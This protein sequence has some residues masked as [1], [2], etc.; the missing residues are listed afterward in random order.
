MSFACAVT[1]ANVERNIGA[2]ENESCVVLLCFGNRVEVEINKSL[3]C[4][5]ADEAGKAGRLAGKSGDATPALARSISVGRLGVGAGG[6]IRGGERGNG[7][8]SH[9]STFVLT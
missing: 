3:T 5:I 6:R 9:T 4:I 2:G 1:G 8:H 7:F